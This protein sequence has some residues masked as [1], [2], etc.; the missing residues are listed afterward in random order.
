MGSDFTEGGS[1]LKATEQRG[2]SFLM[3]RQWMSGSVTRQLAPFISL[4]R[5]RKFETLRRSFLTDIWDRWR[6]TAMIFDLSMNYSTR[7]FGHDSLVFVTKFRREIVYLLLWK[8][9]ECSTFHS[10][11]VVQPRRLCCFWRPQVMKWWTRHPSLFRESQWATITWRKW[12]EMK[13]L[14]IH[15][16][17]WNAPPS[18]EET[19]CFSSQTVWT[20]VIGACSNWIMGLLFLHRSTNNC[21]LISTLHLPYFLPKIYSDNWG[22]E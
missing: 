11:K 9:F 12:Q 6:R 13:I 1:T 20:R 14:E 18:T 3:T 8:S 2:S 21:T 15:L 4:G 10:L 19:K 5:W 7:K 17:I 16:K 22:F